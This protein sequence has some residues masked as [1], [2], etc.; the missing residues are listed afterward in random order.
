MELQ[1][2]PVLPAVAV[3]EEAAQLEVEWEA[4]K[5]ETFEEG[6]AGLLGLASV[7]AGGTRAVPLLVAAEECEALLLLAAL[8]QVE[9]KPFLVEHY[10]PQ[11]AT[12]APKEAV[13]PP[14]T[15]S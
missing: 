2:V 14:V 10:S 11:L 8:Q 9:L 5:A 13:A 3:E 4:W 15:M 12:L 1:W 7:A 6:V